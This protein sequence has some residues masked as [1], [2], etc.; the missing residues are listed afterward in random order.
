[1]EF[2]VVKKENGMHYAGTVDG[3]PVWLK[4]SPAHTKFDEGLAKMIAKQLTQL[5]HAVEVKAE[6]YKRNAGGVK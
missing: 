4:T 6:N 5:G 2:V 1:M 3:S